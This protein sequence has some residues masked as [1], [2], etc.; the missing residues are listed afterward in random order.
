MRIGYGRTDITPRV[1]VEL[2]GFGPFLMRRSESIRDRLWAKA[3]AVELGDQKVIIASLD[4]AGIQRGIAHQVRKLVGAA[5]GLDAKS[6][7]LNC[8]HTHSG[9]NTGGYI[10]WGAPDEPYLE[11]LPQRVADAC[12]ESLENLQDAELHHAEVPCEGIGQ[13]RE[14]DRD[15]LPLE[16]VLQ[17][18][19]RPQ[20]PELTD[21]TCHVVKAIADGELIGFFSYFGC[22]PVVCCQ[23]TTAI[24]GDFCGV[25]TNQIEREHPGSVGLFLQ[26]VQGDVNTCV[27]HKPKHESM[28]ALDII[29]G[30]YAN[31]VREGLLQA[32]PIEVDAI[33]SE[34]EDVIFPRKP[35]TLEKLQNMLA[36]NE[37]ILHAPDATDEDRNTR[38]AMVNTIALRQ[39]IKKKEAG[40]SLEPPTELH[41]IRLGPIA[42]LGSGF[43]FFQSTKHEIC[44]ETKSPLTLL[45][46]LTN[47]TIGYAP[48]RQAAERGGY[49]ADTVPL[50]VCALPHVN[51]HDEVVKR[52]IEL[53]AKLH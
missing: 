24:H 45:M 29:A 26:G 17:K 20:K 28:L 42:F 44:A 6:I 43:E 39:L 36:E 15:A 34:L 14:Y 41:A 48:D 53:E 5:T 19:W 50:I 2:C 21:T 37:A 51:V 33:R 4:L 38:M 27:V 30:R 25:A 12:I 22:H 9:P 13:N 7:M 23:E 32:E 40:E 46:G 1:G 47:D 49:A 52:F 16:E 18:D 35:F 8:T 11:I 3:M 10:G 31:S